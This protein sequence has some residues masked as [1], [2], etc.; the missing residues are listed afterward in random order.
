MPRFRKL[1]PGEVHIGKGATTAAERALFVK[2]IK[3]AQA[4]RIELEPDD[5]SKRT[6]G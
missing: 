5:S 1:D 2:A 3:D 6:R 4:G